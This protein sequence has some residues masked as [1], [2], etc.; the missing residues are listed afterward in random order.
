MSEPP[1]ER[2]VPAD[3]VALPVVAERRPVAGNSDSSRHTL[4]EYV[5]QLITITAGVLIAL[6]IDGLVEWKHNRDLVR[7]ATATITR[8]I[9]DNR[10]ALERHLSEADA[11]E[12]ETDNT[13]QLV[14]ELLDTKASDIKQLGLSFHLST[15]SSA[16]WQS[17]ER[18]GA[19]AHMEYADVQKYAKLYNVQGLY[20][21][22][23]RRVMAQVVS[24]LSSLSAD[25]DPHKAPPADLERFRQQLLGVRA[26][27]LVDR[28]L[29]DSLLRAYKE[30]L[31]Q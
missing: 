11:R 17:A 28:Q 21:G 7:E 6:A 26:A 29:G 13:L 23:Q 18:T 1:A 5:F 25:M 12:N 31:G 2:P 22:E 9:T 8:E 30:T 19:V 16:A 10:A 14:K 4:G 24:A 27:L 15:L 3:D 20:E